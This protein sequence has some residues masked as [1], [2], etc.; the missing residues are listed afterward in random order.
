[1]AFRLSA[2]Q[3]KV[4]C[5]P[6]LPIARILVLM[7]LFLA[8]AAA[9]SWAEAWTLD[10]ED[11]I[12]AEGVTE[13]VPLADGRVLYLLNAQV[14][15]AMHVTS[16]WWWPTLADLA[17]GTTESLF[18]NPYVGNGAAVMATGD[19]KLL[20]AGGYSREIGDFGIH[21]VELAQAYEYDPAS[22][23]SRRLGDMQ[24]PGV[25]ASVPLADG[26][27]LFLGGG[28]AEFYKP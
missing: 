19:G 13:V 21:R 8:P 5:L 1:M 6:L 4:T 22:N 28:V 11:S 18:G 3:V 2:H 17:T 20:L 10:A 15:T 16:N 27:L 25:H 23:T 14:V 26:R 7:L 12:N 9:A 24:T